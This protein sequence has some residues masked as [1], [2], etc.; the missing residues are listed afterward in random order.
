MRGTTLGPPADIAGRA[1]SPG[2]E[3]GIK[4][5]PNRAGCGIN[6]SIDLISCLQF[7]GKA[8]MLMKSQRAAEVMKRLRLDKRESAEVFFDEARQLRDNLAR[9]HDLT[10]KLSWS[11]VIDLAVKT[12]RVLRGCE[13]IEA[14]PRKYRQTR[15]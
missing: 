1:T 15:F 7:I 3:P 6:E 12:I 13:E 11:R 10:T 9:S 5:S 2:T 8:N 14:S 4:S